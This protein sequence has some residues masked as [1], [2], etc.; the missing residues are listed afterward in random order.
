MLVPSLLFL[1][2][3]FSNIEYRWLDKAAIIDERTN[4]EDKE[5][6]G[7]LCPVKQVREVKGVFTLIPI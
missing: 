3:F 4:L 5:I 6:G 1:T 2:L 7:Q